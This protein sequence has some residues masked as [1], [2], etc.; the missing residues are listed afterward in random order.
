MFELKREY[1]PDYIIYKFTGSY[2]QNDFSLVIAFFEEDMRH[3]YRFIF[4]LKEMCPMNK[5]GIEMLQELYIKG[6]SNNCEMILCGLDAQQQMML[7]L[8][9]TNK[10]YQIEKTLENAI[11]LSHQ[12]STDAY[13]YY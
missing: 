3:T 13:Y 1:H 8:F 7:E 2:T 5:H 4:N 11:E 12:E 10:L 9:K 6:V